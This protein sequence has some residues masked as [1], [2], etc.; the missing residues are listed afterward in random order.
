MGS[1]S[2]ARVRAMHWFSVVWSSSALELKA[3][4]MALYVWE[5]FEEMAELLVVF[6]VVVVGRLWRM[7]G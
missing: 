4:M 1:L 7:T 6:I 5:N 3:V 2:S